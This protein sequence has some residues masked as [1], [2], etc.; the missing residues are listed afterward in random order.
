MNISCTDCPSPVVQPM[1]TTTYTVVVSDEN[2][3]FTFESFDY[4]I[5]VTEEYRIGVPEAFTPNNDQINDFIKVDGWGIKNLLEF[6]IYN[7]WGNEVFYTNN[8]DE[9]W[10]GNF[11]D[12]PQP[13]GTYTYLIRAEMWDGSIKALQG[14]FTLIR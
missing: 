8:L 2:E 7:R 6:R 1:E 11:E 3:C 10:D 4:L 13:I 5:Q 12:A 14:T 9:S